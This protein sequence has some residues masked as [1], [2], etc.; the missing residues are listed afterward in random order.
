MAARLILFGSDTCVPCVAAKRALVGVE[1]EYYDVCRRPDLV[2][3]YS[4]RSVPTLLAIDDEGDA[5]SQ[6]TGRITRDGALTLLALASRE[7]ES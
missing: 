4:I 7:D 3:R 6:H 2:G 5:I 1:F